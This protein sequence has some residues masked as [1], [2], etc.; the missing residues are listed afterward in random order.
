MK[1]SMKKSTKNARKQKKPNKP[2]EKRC[3][4]CKN[5]GGSLSKRMGALLCDG[6]FPIKRKPGGGFASLKEYRA[7]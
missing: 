6:C 1:K 3:S 7:Q 4:K 5:T 2:P